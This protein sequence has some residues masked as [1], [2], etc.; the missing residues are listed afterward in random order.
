MNKSIINRTLLTVAIMLLSI[1]A[2]AQKNTFCNPLDLLAGNERACR[3]GE[4][5]VLI[6]QDDYYLFVTGR[7][8]YWY[9][10]DFRDWTYVN[11]PSFPGGVIS[12]IEKEGI[13]YACS[14]NNKNVYKCTEPKKGEWTLTATFDSDRYGDA[15]MFLDDDGRLYL[16]YGWSQIMPFKAVELDVNTFKEIAGPEV[17]FFGDYKHHGFENRRDDDVIFSI[18]NGRRIYYEEEFPWIEGPWVTKHEGKYY[19]QYAAIGLEFLSYS[20]GVYVSDSP[21]G[22]YTYSEHNPLTFKTTG[23]AVGAGHGSTFHDKNGQ[24]WTICMIPAWYAGN[25][26][27]ELAIYPTAVDADGVMHS[28]TA[29]GDY[30]QYWPGT[31]T[32]AVDNNLTGWLLLSQKKR[33]EV[34][35]TFE[36]YKP[37]NA[38]DENFMTG[39][40]ANTGNPGEYLTVDLGKVSDIH[41]IQCNFDHIGATVNVGRGFAPS[42]A[43]EHYQCYTVEISNDN[44]GW[45]TVIDKSDNK[46]DLRH[47]YTEFSKPVKGRY[48]KITNVATHD[49]AKFAVK[50]L[51]VFGNPD[52]VAKVKVSD[53]KAVRNQADR[54]EATL[55][56]EPVKGADG[57]VVRYGIEPD[58][59]YNSY[60]VYDRNSLVIHSLNTDPEYYYEIEAFDSGLDYYKEISEIVNGTGAEIELTK[61]KP[62]ERPTWG[63]GGADVPRMMIHQGQNDYVFED[64]EPGYKYTLRHSYGPVL[65]EGE[66]TEKELIGES[67]RPTITANLTELGTGNRITGMLELRVYPGKEKGKIV[68]TANYNRRMVFA[69][70]PVVN[71]DNTVTF[72]LNA[73]GAK[74]VQINAQFAEKQNMDKNPDGIW[75]ITLGPVAPDIYPYSFIV[76]GVTIMDPQN[77]EW[78]P[79]EKFK[80]S[81]VEVR[82]KEPLN[83][84][85]TNVPHGSVDYTYYFSKA[86]GMYAPVVVYTPPGYDQSKK[87]YPVF[88]LISGTTDT[89]ETFFKVGRV[90]FI[91]DNLIAQGKAKDMIIVM[92]YGNPAYYLKEPKFMDYFS[93]DFIDD[94]MPFIENNYRTIANRDNRAIA[95]FSRGGGQA[96]R[97]GLGHFDK[98]SHILSY[99]SYIGTEEFEKNYK[100]FYEDPL[101]TNNMIKLYWLGVDKAD[102]LYGGATEYMELMDKYGIKTV[103]LQTEG[104]RGHTWMAVK[105]FLN[106]TLPLLF[107]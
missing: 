18:F 43:P 57:Y 39:W 54:R 66:L 46:L 34:S 92:P 85:I 101:K 74:S 19:L 9:S 96:L 90:N 105:R 22:P 7:R 26:G 58:K 6:Y 21:M 1:A 25:G 70:S 23:F 38:V 78:F 100:S 32:D 97:C 69:S 103:T 8:G 64:L 102:F 4:P 55:L 17:L 42:P 95:G 36:D 94:L 56:W 41:A 27:A 86:L 73:P 79:N 88:Y 77:P 76:D 104:L 10:P 13:L 3:G 2:M 50:D 30:P 80:N 61:I 82:G 87:K 84:E 48:I 68:V 72:N 81:L 51:R 63:W 106:E 75:T 11:S 5:V 29:Y 59:L 60:M 99:S 62:G 93:K 37:E 98:F 44:T 14:M 35:S 15:N 67:T 33:T 83:H 31:K 45:T 28:N 107:Q 24:L 16:F 49:D 52:V 20:H 47:D 89:E 65:W 91:L 12:V 40:C 53:F 71:D